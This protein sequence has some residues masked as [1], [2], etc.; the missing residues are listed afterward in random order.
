MHPG[1][2]I[3]SVRHKESGFVLH[4]LE[5]PVEKARR[6]IMRETADMID[7]FHSEG[8]AVVGFALVIWDADGGSSAT[9][10]AGAGSTIPS[11]AMPDFVRN[12]LLAAKINEWGKD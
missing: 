6:A 7:G 12:R 3:R 9:V 8:P 1:C 10:R 11:I 5:Q 2:R 4:R